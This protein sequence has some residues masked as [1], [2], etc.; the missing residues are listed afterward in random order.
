MKEFLSF[1]KR[2][3]PKEKKQEKKKK[4]NPGV[5]T[6]LERTG[7]GFVEERA[8]DEDAAVEVPLPAVALDHN[9]GEVFGGEQTVLRLWLAI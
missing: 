3:N 4:G 6:N 1:F 2:K 8:A 9:V 5:G 7:Q